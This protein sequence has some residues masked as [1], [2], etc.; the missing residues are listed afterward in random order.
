MKWGYLILPMK[1]DPFVGEAQ[2]LAQLSGLGA[3]G[4]ELVTTLP[5]H[6]GV[7]LLFKKAAP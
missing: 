2:L 1:A 6:S 4:W 5:S 3:K 7:Y